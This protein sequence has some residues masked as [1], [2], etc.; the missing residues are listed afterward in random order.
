[1]ILYSDKSWVCTVQVSEI[2]TYIYIYLGLVSILPE[3]QQDGGPG[4]NLD[5]GEKKNFSFKGSFDLLA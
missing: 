5:F 3:S 2:Y 4:S 1:M